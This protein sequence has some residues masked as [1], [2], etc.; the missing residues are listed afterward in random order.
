MK[1]LFIFFSITL[2]TVSFSQTINDYEFLVIP[3]KYP[4]QK[5]E[6]QYRINTTLEVYFKQ[7]LMS[8]VYLS[9]NWPKFRTIHA[10][11]YTWT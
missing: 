11:P 6:N 9:Q 5:K 8:L 4:F 7:T 1:N 2:V 3:I 10:K